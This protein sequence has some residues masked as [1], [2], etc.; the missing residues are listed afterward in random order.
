MLLSLHIV[1]TQKP[2]VDVNQLSQSVCVFLIFHIK[3]NPCTIS[4][5]NKRASKGHMSAMTRMPRTKKRIHKRK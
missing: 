3:K 1:H 5:A 2:T 4:A